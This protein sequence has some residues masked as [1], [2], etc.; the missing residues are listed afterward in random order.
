MV[1][2]IKRIP[3]HKYMKSGKLAAITRDPHDTGY[4]LVDMSPDLR[5]I[6]G[7]RHVNYLK[8]DSVIQTEYTLEAVERI[9]KESNREYSYEYQYLRVL[10]QNDLDEKKWENA[11]S[12]SDLPIGINPHISREEKIWAGEREGNVVAGVS[13]A[14]WVLVAW[15]WVYFATNSG[16][17]AWFAVL[18]AVISSF[19][20]LTFKW[21]S[22]K[23]ASTKKLQELR[24]HKQ[25]LRNDQKAQQVQAM[26]DLDNRLK[27]YSNWERLSP[28]EFEHALVYRLR[29]DGHDLSVTKYVGDGGID[30]EGTSPGGK[31]LIVQAKK[32]KSNVG[33]AVVREM[34]GVRESLPEKPLSMIVSL[35]GFTR[36]AK[37]LAEK[38]NVILMSIKNDL[39]RV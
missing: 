36:G 2:E 31:P 23:K 26:A 10:T 1:D 21:R 15:L 12:L 20:L 29:E 30:L 37:E 35:V 24:A 39:L 27:D 38:E 7:I 14:A 8:R 22:S 5:G 17:A 28:K 11:T 25:L 13:L 6:K 16:D 34:I 18:V 9:Q 32:Y 19:F 33:V 4:V 3:I